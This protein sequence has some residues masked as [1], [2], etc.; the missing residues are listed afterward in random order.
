VI[1]ETIVQ[2]LIETPEVSAIVG[3]RVYSPK[4]PDGAD[5]PL[6]IVGKAG[7]TGQYD[8][9]GDAGIENARVQVDCYSA[10]GQAAVL[11]LKSA[12]RRKL[13]GFKGGLASGNPCSIDSSFLINDFD[14]SEPNTERTGPRLRR[15]TLEFNIW[16][17][18][19]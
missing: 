7:A 9:E 1:D 3:D 16:H 11:V 5:F 8:M 18:E 12:V 2:L 10:D 6:I 17:R 13:S 14:N 4:A 15:R 19:L